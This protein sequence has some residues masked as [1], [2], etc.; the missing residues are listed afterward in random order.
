MK[1]LAA[2]AN[3]FASYAWYYVFSEIDI[4]IKV[5]STQKEWRTCLLTSV[6]YIS[7]YWEFAVLPNTTNNCFTME[8]LT[9]TFPLKRVIL[10]VK[11]NVRV[12]ATHLSK[13]FYTITRMVELQLVRFVLS[14]DNC[15]S[16]L[17]TI[18]VLIYVTLI[19]F[20]VT[21]VSH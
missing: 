18:N 19:F 2:Y 1:H 12:V 6:C 4:S 11:Q 21:L 15:T 8:V 9:E 17:F 14:M 20:I 13:E 7:Y 3:C 10:A 16:F 5:I